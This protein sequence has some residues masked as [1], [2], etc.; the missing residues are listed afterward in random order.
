MNLIDWTRTASFRSQRID[1]PSP[2]GR[3]EMAGYV[4][5]R[6]LSWNA[7][8]P[9]A[10]IRP[11]KAC[12]HLHWTRLY[13]VSFGRKLVGYSRGSDSARWLRHFFGTR[14]HQFTTVSTEHKFTIAWFTNTPSLF[15]RSRKSQH[16][17]CSQTFKISLSWSVVLLFVLSHCW[18]AFFWVCDQNMLV[19]YSSRIQEQLKWSFLRFLTYEVYCIWLWPTLN[20][21]Y[22][23][24]VLARVD[25][26]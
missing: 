2:C 23:L 22:S 3:V 25:I 8:S 12:S 11:W 20:Q 15:D 5:S 24:D 1:R 16:V 7:P 4:C 9:T 26:A 18:L 14:T 6:T 21:A 17:R 19:C 13:I 10:A